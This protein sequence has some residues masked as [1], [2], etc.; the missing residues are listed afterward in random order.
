VPETP[1][2]PTRAPLRRG[3]GT[4]RRRAATFEDMAARRAERLVNLVLCLLSTRQYLSAEQIRTAV[5]G[6]EPNDGSARADEAFHRMFERDKGELRDLG[7]PLET[8]RN[9]YF[10]VD[11]GYRIAR[12]SYELPAIDFTPQEAT[13]VGLAIRLWQSAALGQAAH[14]ALMKLRAAGVTLDEAALP[15]VVPHVDAS[16][17]ALPPV[18]DAVR[19]R[20][21][22]R[23]GYVKHGSRETEIRRVQPWGVVSWRARWYLV[24]YDLDRAD[25]RSFRL[26]RVE[27]AVRPLGERDAFERPADLDLVAV[28]SSRAPETVRVARVRV[29]GP[30][31]DHLR[32]MAASVAPDQAGDVLTIEYSDLEWLARQVASAGA[33]AVALDPPELIDSVVRRLR[34][35]ATR[36]GA[37]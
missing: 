2:E 1:V 24:G 6:Y 10:D 12:R 8:G 30:R 22:V 33:A 9:S 14:G 5:P 3:A 13:A 18:L 26:S 16:D 32:R 4:H 29:R 28:V 17:P 36:V 25:A 20:Q 27:G 35:V 31:I 11:D 15:G 7:V 19:A 34:R 37:P 23:F 21:A